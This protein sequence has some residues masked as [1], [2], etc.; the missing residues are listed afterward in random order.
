VSFVRLQAL[1]NV[2]QQVPDHAEAWN[3][4]AALWLELGEPKRAYSA[5]GE[6]LR[7]EVL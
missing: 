4:V 1:T 5:L 2:T 6:C 7:W 3:N